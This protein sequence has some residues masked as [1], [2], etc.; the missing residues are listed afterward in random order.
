MWRGVE[1]EGEVWERVRRVVRAVIYT[2][3]M[4]QLRI[5]GWYSRME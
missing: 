5:V 1:G 3:E 4:S 2:E